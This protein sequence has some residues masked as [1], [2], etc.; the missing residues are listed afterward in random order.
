MRSCLAQ[1]NIHCAHFA[2]SLQRTLQESFFRK[3]Y[4]INRL[5]MVRAGK[6]PGSADTGIQQDLVTNLREAR[7]GSMNAAAQHK[8]LRA[9]IER[10]M[11]RVEADALIAASTHECVL[12][13]KAL[14]ESESDAEEG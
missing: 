3:K 6:T 14:K 7:K 12:V 11:V 8:R 1:E 5:A 2:L 13:R 9:A 10:T 4:V